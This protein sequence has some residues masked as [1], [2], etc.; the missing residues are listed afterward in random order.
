MK[1]TAI[2]LFSLLMR[3]HATSYAQ[4]VTL[5]VKDAKL[6][7]V[8]SNITRQTGYL[9][10]YNDQLLKKARPVTIDL[11]NVSLEQ[12]LQ[13]I[14]QKQPF[15]YMISEKNIAVGPSSTLEPAAADTTAPPK[16]ERPVPTVQVYFKVVDAITGDIITGVNVIVEGAGAGTVSDER[17]E[18]RIATAKGKT[19]VFSYVG[20]EEH[21]EKMTETNSNVIIR[22][23]QKPQEMKTTV[24]T[25][26]FNR[27]ASSFTGAAVTY[28]GEELRKVGNAN[29]FQSLKNMAPSMVLDNFSLGSN[30]NALPTIQ[31]RGTSTFPSPESDIQANLKGNY[32]KSPNEPLFILDGF[33]ASLE[34]IYDLDMNRIERMIILKDAASKAM[35]GSKAAN[36]V[37][38]IETKKS[39][40]SRALVTYNGSVDID[41]PDL[42]SYNLTNSHEKLQ[43]ELIDGMYNATSKD[44]NEVIRLQQLYN[45]RKKI[46]D[47]GLYTDWLA[48]PLREGVGHKHNISVDLSGAAVSLLADVTYREVNGVMIGSQ[49]KNISA[50]VNTSY[51]VKKFQFRNIMSVISDNS[52]ESPYG[53]FAGYAIMNPYWKSQEADG[54]IPFYSEWISNSQRYTNPLYNSTIN[55]RNTTEYLNFIDNFYFEWN[56]IPGLKAVSR[57]GFDIKNNRADEFYPASHTIFDSYMDI[58]SVQKR[59][60]LYQINNGKSTRVTGDLNL[61]YT[62]NLGIHTFFGNLGMNVSEQKF[63]EM[64]HIVEGFTSDKMD[65]VLLGGQYKIDSRPQGMEMVSREIGFLGSFSYTYDNRYFTDLTLRT[66]ASSQFGSDKRWAPFWSAGLGW[67]LHNEN[68]F[69]QQFPF[70]DQFKLRGSVGSTGNPNFATNASVAT[71]EY[72]RD[73]LYQNFPGSFLTNLP[74]PDL[75]WETK[76]D[77]NIGADVSILNR[78]NIRFDYYES[79]TENLVTRLTLPTSTGFS[80]VSENLGRVKN[81]G[82][83]INANWMIWSKGRNFISINGGIETNRNK[84]VALSDAMKDFNN[85][86]DA[87]AAKLNRG[88][89][90]KKYV[91]G[92]SMNTI[93]A[94]P[95]LGI[96]PSTGR[97][98]YVKK[99][100]TTTFLWN[101]ADMVAAGNSLPAFTGIFGISGEYQGF[102]FNITGRYLGGNQLYNQTLVD[103]VENVDMAYNVDKR[104][105]TGRWLYPGQPALFKRLGTFSYFDENGDPVQARERTRATTR[106]VQDRN[107]IS[108]GA[109]SAYYQFNDNLVKRMGMQRLR[110]GANMNEIATFSTIKIERGTEYPFARTLSIFLSATF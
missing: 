40:S 20:Y 4:K 15:V 101:A 78:V 81:S 57:I 104:V 75:Q 77:Y 68:F 60:G 42:T 79:Y 89:P 61:Q 63:N 97:E 23:K 93:W 106:F 28:T 32:L 37:I 59:K 51:R 39:V 10:F 88:T 18:A 17:G 24:V 38:V 3:V 8:F 96:D 21:R 54:T 74:N 80:D 67:N 1:L 5:T 26:I 29:V 35:Y 103:R 100:G 12:A 76:M 30:P 107:E 87:E 73:R 95:S 27:K 46:A 69:R 98:I 92:M 19:V 83:E 13:A 49:R 65:N 6:E 9:F 108:I 33:E 70:F 84:I 31:L 62:K 25:G 43:A 86:M 82:I 44:E 91:D 94:V 72:Y 2:F 41:I 48:K 64:Y 14:F 52:A 53:S 50:N 11:K 34:R 56:I 85:R 7:S 45:A 22:L 55:T 109:V 105:L 36:G 16:R 58:D 71:Y 102:G 66:S 90:V 47:E 99:D 110:V